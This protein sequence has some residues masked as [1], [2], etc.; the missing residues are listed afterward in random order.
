MTTWNTSFKNSISS[1]VIF[2]SLV[3]NKFKNK[4]NDYLNRHLSIKKKLFH[5]YW[6]NDQPALIQYRTQTI[7]A[8]I[9]LIN[10]RSS[11][12]WSWIYSESGNLFTNKRSFSKIQW[13]NRTCTVSNSCR[14]Q[15]LQ[16]L[17][18]TLS[19][20]DNNFLSFCRIFIWWQVKNITFFLKSLHRVYSVDVFLDG[21]LYRFLQ[22][23]L[24]IYRRRSFL[25]RVE[26]F[27]NM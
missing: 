7:W 3:W 18:R 27:R 4:R 1:M 26:C 17:S 5:L 23:Y 10:D 2:Q 6:E 16:F 19:K 22:N 20:I 25:R 11:S 15:W 14:N 12:K 13:L 8:I 21:H 24:E 9:N